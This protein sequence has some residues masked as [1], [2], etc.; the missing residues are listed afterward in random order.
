[1]ERQV[2]RIKCEFCILQ[3]QE[4]MGGDIADLL[5]HRWED[6]NK[7][8]RSSKCMLTVQRSI[9]SHER[10]FARFCSALLS[11]LAQ[12]VRLPSGI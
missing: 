5:T 3:L 8:T 11:L 10:C 7:K 1:M 2:H 12:D 6:D 4:L 9:I